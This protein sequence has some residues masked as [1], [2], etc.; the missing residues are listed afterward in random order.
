MTIILFF[1]TSYV[2]TLKFKFKTKLYK[3]VVRRDPYYRLV[4]VRG[5][6]SFMQLKTVIVL[7]FTIQSK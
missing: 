4:N 6:P 7:L 3:S 5:L 2:L 1:Y